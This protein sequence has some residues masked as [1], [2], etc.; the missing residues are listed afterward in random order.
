LVPDATLSLNGNFQFWYPLNS[1]HSFLIRP[2]FNPPPPFLALRSSWF[3][4]FFFFLPFR[5]QTKHFQIPHIFIGS[6]HLFSF[7][8]LRSTGSFRLYFFLYPDPPMPLFPPLKLSLPLHIGAPIVGTFFFRA[9]NRFFQSNGTSP[10]FF[11]L[12]VP[13]GLVCS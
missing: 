12:G 4:G 7:L 10:P 6:G 11:F 8:L 13:F 2:F 1:W 3:L 5:N 9:T